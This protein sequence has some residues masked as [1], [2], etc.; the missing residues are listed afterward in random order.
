MS[1]HF[2]HSRYRAINRIGPKNVDVISV[3]LGLLLGDSYASNRS[4]EGVKIR[5]KQSI[6]HKEYLFSLYSFFWLGVIV[7][8]LNLENTLEPLKGKIIFIM[9]MS[10]IHIHL[11]VFLWIYKLFYLKG[12]KIVPINIVKI[13]TP[14]T[15]AVL[16]Q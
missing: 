15:L 16:D 1:K 11:E 3:I 12:K 10:L 13:L 8:I 14:L 6:I 4:G 5:I 7:L 9:V 2:F